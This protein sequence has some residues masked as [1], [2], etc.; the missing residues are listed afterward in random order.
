MMQIKPNRAM[1]SQK[2]S[3]K[4]SDPAEADDTTN[5]LIQH[6]P[7]QNG[8]T[9]DAHARRPR[10]LSLSS[11][12]D[13]NATL[14]SSHLLAFLP[15]RDAESEHHRHSSSSQISDDSV[16]LSPLTEDFSGFP[17]SRRHSEPVNSLWLEGGNGSFGMGPGP[18]TDSDDGVTAMD[19]NTLNF[20]DFDYDDSPGS[21]SS[22]ITPVDTPSGNEKKGSF[23]SRYQSFSGISHQSS[24]S[25]LVSASDSQLDD[26]E[27]EDGGSANVNV[28]IRVRPLSEQENKRGDRNVVVVQ[29]PSS[30]LIEGDK[31][32]QFT[33]NHVFPGEATQQDVLEECG[34][35][36][37]VDM[38]VEGYA[39]TAFAYGQTGSGKTYTITGP[40]RAVRSHLQAESMSGLI[41]RSLAYLFDMIRLKP[42]MSFSLRSSYLEIYNEQVKDLLNLTGRDSLQ[43]RWSKDKGFYVENLFV[44]EC[45]ILDDM[46]AVLEEGMS[47]KA[48]ATN[49]VNEHSSRSHTIMT[50]NID[51]ELPD[52]DDGD[53]YIT[54]HGKLS[55]VDLAGSE[56]V[57]ELGS[58]AELLSETTNINKSL[59]TLGNCISSLSDLRK[60]SGHIPYRDSKLTKLLADSLGGS[61]ITLMIACIS[62]SSYCLSESLNTLRYANRARRIK[63]KPV[64]RMDPREKL[65][66]SLKREVRLLRSENQY[67][68]QRL[69]F[70][71]TAQ[72]SLRPP[73]ANGNDLGEAGFGPGE[74]PPDGELTP[75]PNGRTLVEEPRIER[76]EAPLEGSHGGEGGGGGGK[77]NYHQQ[78]DQVPSQNNPT[79]SA[80][81]AADNSLYEML[82]EYM[83]EN[84][85]LRSENSDLHSVKEKARRDHDVVAR[86]NDRLLKKLEDLERVFTASPYSLPSSFNSRTSSGQSTSLRVL[87]NNQPLPLGQAHPLAHHSP[88]NKSQHPSQGRSPPGSLQNS[89]DKRHSHGGSSWRQSGELPPVDSVKG[90]PDGYRSSQQRPTPPGQRDI[91]PSQRSFPSMS[92]Q[93]PFNPP[94]TNHSFP[95]TQSKQSE[96]A[97]TYPGAGHSYPPTQRG[98]KKGIDSQRLS[99][100]SQS[101]PPPTGLQSS[102]SGSMG[103]VHEDLQQSGP[104][105]PV[106]ATGPPAPSKR[107]SSVSVR[108]SLSN[109]SLPGGKHHQP[110]ADIYI[111]SV[112][113]TGLTKDSSPRRDT[114]NRHDLQTIHETGSGNPAAAAATSLRHHPSTTS[115]A[116]VGASHSQVALRGRPPKGLSTANTTS[117]G[118][119]TKSKKTAWSG[120]GGSGTGGGGG[121]GGTGGAGSSQQPSKNLTAS[122]GV[123]LNTIPK[124]PAV[125]PPPVKYKPQGSNKMLAAATNN[126]DINY[127]GPNSDSLND[128]NKKLREELQA[129]DGEIE[130]MKYVNKSK[131][132]VTGGKGKRR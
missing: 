77:G 49:N 36:K 41:Q 47:Q 97:G 52:P 86:E 27:I 61:G 23:N 94:P 70:P 19:L 11:A 28:V 55:F 108:S 116:T 130:Y 109:P 81:S 14:S 69:E 56:K 67:L 125:T 88:P 100:T 111:P 124:T 8:A 93:P 30:L 66:S 48:I 121:G 122:N 39:C 128:L 3:N 114:S 22:F 29:S 78:Q 99:N 21:D 129:L 87:N 62:P 80:K 117:T 127:K 58:T 10:A 43:V 89:L 107:D 35:K 82:Q 17:G 60:R 104:P 83:V 1:T 38:A 106:G 118:Y 84:E 18:T 123:P 51:T 91:P 50:I 71:G 74:P 131:A 110:K 9:S 63:N 32:K 6:L 85:T 20:D 64:V 44:V 105:P 65:I 42:K 54:K 79:V 103:T 4:R 12:S 46:L 25:T 115:E 75:V 90:I 45:E 40:P 37:M 2:D 112:P 15:A 26:G 95:R 57:K 68:R 33:F 101:F 132:G 73:I 96:L 5:A 119:S 53:L 24:R 92:T 126:L 98:P 34:I 13:A 113:S 76:R 16:A 59:L 120:A 102:F 7:D 72:P 31:N